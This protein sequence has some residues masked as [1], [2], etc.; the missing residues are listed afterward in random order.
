MEFL[1]FG[2]DG[3]IRRAN[4]KIIPEEQNLMSMYLQRHGKSVRD[5]LINEES[6]LHTDTASKSAKSLA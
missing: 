1:S 6:K 4:G 2:N 5:T 3:M